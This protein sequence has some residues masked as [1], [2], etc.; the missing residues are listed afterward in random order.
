M[1]D[2][3]RQMSIAR[4]NSCSRPGRV[5]N[6]AGTAMAERERT[7]NSIKELVEEGSYA[8]DPQAVA[9]AILRRLVR[10]LASGPSASERPG[11]TSD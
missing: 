7:M 1:S 11:R 2:A 4:V 5:P 9:D 10:G 8:V 3:S 6:S